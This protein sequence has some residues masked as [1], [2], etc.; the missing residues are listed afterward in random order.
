MWDYLETVSA[1]FEKPAVPIRRDQPATWRQMEH[2][3][4]LHSMLIKQFGVGHTQM[5]WNL[6]QNEKVS[7][8]FAALWKTSPNDLLTSFDGASFHMPPEQT[9]K[10]WNRNNAWWHTDQSPTRH[11]FECVQSWV[12]G[13]DVAEGDATLAVLEGSHHLHKAF[14]E[15]FKLTACLTSTTEEGK[16]AAK[17]IKKDWFKLLP[18][19][20]E[21]FKE[22]GCA[23]A[24]ITCPAGSMVFWDS[25]TIHHGREA[26]K[27]RVNRNR[28]RCIAY[29]CMTPRKRA[30]P[31]TLKKR[32]KAFEGMR[33][34]SHWPHKLHLNPTAPRTYGS[35]V[36]NIA[37]LP[38]PTL[39]ALGRRLVGFR[40]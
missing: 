2:L 22:Q 30:E 21:W 27:G 1:N 28:H 12:T 31:L 29:M 33:T 34:T 26:L 18:E 24:Y 36:Q 25:R 17:A 20:V 8:P 9:G 7:A 38:P 11:G 35:S 16:K 10:G 4:P 14:S 5:S 19:H 3:F 37:P 6:R 39:S 32:I 15:K 23:P 40:K 13:I